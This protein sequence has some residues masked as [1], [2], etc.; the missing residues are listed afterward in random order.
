MKP[1]F[2][3]IDLDFK[4][5]DFGIIQRGRNEGIDISWSKK[6]KSYIIISATCPEVYYKVDILCDGSGFCTCPSF[7]QV[8]SKK[9]RPCKHIIALDIFLAERARKVI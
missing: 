8:Q 5:A 1:P 6:G 9:N 3:Y 7:V 2:E 4:H